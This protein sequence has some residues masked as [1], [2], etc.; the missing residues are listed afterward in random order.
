[1]KGDPCHQATRGLFADIQAPDQHMS[2]VT[3]TQ[4]TKKDG[5]RNRPCNSS[6]TV[7]PLSPRLRVFH[8]FPPSTQVKPS[9]DYQ[10][11]H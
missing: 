9:A 1:M 5:T 8:P 7:R 2:T 4:P 10:P 3:A 6:R 11:S